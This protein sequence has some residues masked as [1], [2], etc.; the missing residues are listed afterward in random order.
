LIGR[1]LGKQAL[2]KWGKKWEDD[3]KMR[4][5]FLGC[6]DVKSLGLRI[7]TSDSVMVP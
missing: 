4:L 7:V 6:E 2:Q 5:R 3:I 1:H